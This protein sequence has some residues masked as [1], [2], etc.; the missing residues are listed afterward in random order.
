VVGGGVAANRRL[1]AAF[2]AEAKR[3]GLNVYL[4][5]LSF[6]TDNA[7]MIAAAGYYQLRHGMQKNRFDV[8]ADLKV[9]NWK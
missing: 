8:R 5:N 1:R 9:E 4:P 3:R 2:Q 6:C 7:A